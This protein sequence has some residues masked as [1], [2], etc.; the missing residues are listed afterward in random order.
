MK[1][2]LIVPC[3]A[4]GMLLYA[5]TAQ[6]AF[7]QVLRDTPVRAAASAGAKV[8]GT[9]KKGWIV[10]DMT[11]DGSS[12][13]WIR[14]VEFQTK[15][16][17]GMA[18]AHF[19]Y[20]V[21]NAYISA[22]DVVQVADGDGTPLQQARAAS[23]ATAV[24][25][26]GVRVER[27][28]APQLTDLACNGAVDEAGL[29]AALEAWVQACNAVL[30]R[31][32]G[33]APDEAAM[34]ML[35]WADEDPFASAD[36]EAMDKHMAVLLD[37]WLS[38]RYGHPQTPLGADDQKVL[39][40]LASYGLIP[41]MAEGTTFFTADVSALRKRVSFVPPVAAYSDYMSLRDSQPSVL[42]TDGG[43]RY[44]VKE[45]GTWAVQWER[46]LNTVPAD[47]V[48]FTAGK[49]RYLE[50]MTHILFSDLPNTPAFPHHN[51]G[52]MEKAW[53]AALQSVALENPGT[54][55]TALI[56]EFLDK[57]KANDNR[58]SAAYAKALWNKM[59]SPS[60]PRTK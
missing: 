22:E 26:Q 17:E 60:F 37:R 50:F 48:Y 24:A 11:G 27:M 20:K 30:G 54:Q 42:F 47:S 7:W 40:L 45:M 31:L 1:K 19:M 41:Q 43:C 28:V 38:A 10:S 44:P 9:A 23:T 5:G 4:L 6:A 53:I 15:A 46:Y 16:G 8:L 13:Q 52:R 29:K 55:T 56:M 2:I 59:H 49:K 39:A 51:K 18:Y 33:M 34:T 14:M 25:A 58:L 32:E 12:P 57:I 21:P 36:V 35:A 3:C